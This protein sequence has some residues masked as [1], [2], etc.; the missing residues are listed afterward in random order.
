VIC[1]CQGAHRR[2][3]VCACAAGRGA[4]AGPGSGCGRHR[5]T[6]EQAAEAAP[7]STGHAG[8][9]EV[10]TLVGRRGARWSVARGG[11]G[12]VRGGFQAVVLWQRVW[13]IVDT[14]EIRD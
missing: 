10:A 11:A 3:W 14:L 12:P 13:R 2:R 8:G 5:I 7:G 6:K 1:K 9:G 4:A